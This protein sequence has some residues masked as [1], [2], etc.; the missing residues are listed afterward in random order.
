MNSIKRK[1]KYYFRIHNAEELKSISHLLSRRR[2]GARNVDSSWVEFNNYETF[3]EWAKTFRWYDYMIRVYF[4][5]DH[6]RTKFHEEIKRILPFW[7][8]GNDNCSKIDCDYFMYNDKNKDTKGIEFL[9]RCILA[10]EN[11]CHDEEDD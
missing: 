11:Y 8:C 1:L 3:L 4:A 9:W 6:R 5:T 2:F 7:S 10:D